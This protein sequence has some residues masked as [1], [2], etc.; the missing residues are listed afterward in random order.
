MLEDDFEHLE[1]A[2]Y[3]IILVGSV[4]D[5]EMTILD[6]QSKGIPIDE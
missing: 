2:T 3:T 6:Q 4:L 5:V 1:M